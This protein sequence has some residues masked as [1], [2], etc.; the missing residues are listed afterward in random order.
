MAPI[1]WAEI[2]AFNREA[3]AGLSAW[4]KLLIRRVDDRVRAISLGTIDP[5]VGLTEPPAQ[6]RGLGDFLRAKAAE[7]RKRKEKANG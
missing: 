4:D 6:R 1:T 7:S 5:T 2:G 3:C